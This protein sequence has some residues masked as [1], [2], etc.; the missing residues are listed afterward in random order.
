MKKEPFRITIEQYDKKVSIE[1]EHSDVSMDE[2]FT[3]IR[4]LCMAA[5]YHPNTVDEYFGEDV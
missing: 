3:I 5:G 4:Q 1:M 2:L